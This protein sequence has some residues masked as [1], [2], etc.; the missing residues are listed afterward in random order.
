MYLELCGDFKPY[1]SP[2]QTQLEGRDDSADHAVVAGRTA[3]EYNQRKNRKG[4][5]W[6][7]HYHAGAMETGSYMILCV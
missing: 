5:F 7:D 2:L 6:E 1:S 4:V 3:Q